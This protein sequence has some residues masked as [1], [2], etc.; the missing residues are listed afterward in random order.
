MRRLLLALCLLPLA[1][2]LA[3]APAAA[4]TP[5]TPKIMHLNIA[6]GEWWAGGDTPVR[7]VAATARAQRPDVIT[8]NEICYDQYIEL[9]DALKPLDGNGWQVKGWGYVAEADSTRYT[10]CLGPH[11]VDE[12]CYAAGTCRLSIGSA[13]LTRHDAHTGTTWDLP[14]RT[15]AD[16]ALYKLYCVRTWLPVETGPLRLQHSQVCTTHLDPVGGVVDTPTM[17][18]GWVSFCLP[19]SAAFAG[20]DLR[21]CQASVIRARVEENLMVADANG[22]YA[23]LILTGDMNNRPDEPAFT[24]YDAIKNRAA[25]VQAWRPYF[26]FADYQP[27]GTTPLKFHFAEAGAPADEPTFCRVSSVTYATPPTASTACDAGYQ[28]VKLDHVLY[29]RE[30]WHSPATTVTLQ[31]RAPGETGM[32][33]DHFRLDSTLAWNPLP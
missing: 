29:Q 2:A 24:S 12:P 23:P 10:R 9:R 1:L 21:H 7:A 5:A 14:S 30:Y 8:L 3:P 22:R 20:E 13:I 11:G 19:K 6:G 15:R 28:R 17:A 4:A 18:G 26:G 32:L 27:A 33:S 16:G 31:Q 25:Q